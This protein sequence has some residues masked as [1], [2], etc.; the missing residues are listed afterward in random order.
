MPDAPSPTKPWHG[1]LKV[2]RFG[3]G[4]AVSAL[5]VSPAGSPQRSSSPSFLRHPPA[6]T[7]AP[8]TLAH[9]V[10]S[11]SPSPNRIIASDRERAEEYNRVTEHLLV[12]SM[13]QHF[14]ALSSKTEL[15]SLREQRKGEVTQGDCVEA[16]AGLKV[17]QGGVSALQEA[18]DGVVEKLAVLETELKEVAAEKEKLREENKGLLQE[19][20]ER[21]RDDMIVELKLDS[22]MRAV[23]SESQEVAALTKQ[24][25]SY[26]RTAKKMANTEKSNQNMKRQIA[27]LTAAREEDQTQIK[28]LKAELSAMRM[29]GDVQQNEQPHEEIAND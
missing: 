28:S 17:V 27:V 8:H 24:L 14:P 18:Y 16:A 25:A 23:D 4:L 13:R 9:S 15:R 7:S 11:R 19:L 3:E 1:A 6:I 20:D 29:K 5:S 21:D 12:E 10:Y 22:A 2:K 26:K